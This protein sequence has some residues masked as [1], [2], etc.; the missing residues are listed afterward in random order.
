MNSIRASDVACR[1]GGDEFVL[2]LP[3]KFE[4][5]AHTLLK[6]VNRQLAVINACQGKGYRMS[7]SFGTLF[8][9]YSEPLDV[10][11]AI[12]QMDSRMYNYKLGQ[13]GETD[14]QKKA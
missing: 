14:K 11:S 8:Y 2:A 12:K 10:E 7:F 4:E 13:T 9:D 1:F 6:K 3:N 5:N